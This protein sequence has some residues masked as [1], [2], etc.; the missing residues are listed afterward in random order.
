MEMMFLCQCIIYQNSK[1]NSTLD[2]VYILVPKYFLILHCH[3]N[4]TEHQSNCSGQTVS[5]YMAA[6]VRAYSTFQII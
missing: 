6:C 5:A 2:T 3:C 1:I 4:T